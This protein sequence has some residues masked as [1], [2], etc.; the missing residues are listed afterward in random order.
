MAF[1]KKNRLSKKVEINKVFKNGKTVK[2]S[3]LFIRFLS[4]KRDCS[5]FVFIIPSKHVRLA[6]SRN[7]IRR[8]LLEE[9]A[10]NPFLLKLKYDIAV[11][12]YKSVDKNERDLLKEELVNLLTKIK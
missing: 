11:S 10:R 7:K 1:P 2:G 5:R 8:T 3:F 9:V 4:N 6:A 12:L